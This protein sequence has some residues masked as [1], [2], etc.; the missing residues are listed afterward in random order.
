MRKLLK[1][2][3]VSKEVES[4]FMQDLRNAY[5]TAKAAAGNAGE[6]LANMVNPVKDL[7]SK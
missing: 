5:T 2:V 6:W 7:K 3:L 4:E 1:Q